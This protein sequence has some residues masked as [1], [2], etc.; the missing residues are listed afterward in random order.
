METE[1]PRAA[2]EVEVAA[3]DDIDTIV[4]AGTD[5][6]GDFKTST[7]AFNDPDYWDADI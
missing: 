5:S 4:A 6:N 3:T 7:I 2:R 1:H